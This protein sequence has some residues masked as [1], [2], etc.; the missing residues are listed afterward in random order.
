MSVEMTDGRHPET[1]H[2]LV[3]WV[4][5]TS[6]EAPSRTDGG[7]RLVIV[8]SRSTGHDY[9]PAFVHPS[10]SLHPLYTPS[11]PVPP[12]C[13]LLPFSLPTIAAPTH[14]IDLKSIASLNVA[15]D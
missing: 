9:T 5:I 14:S 15:S 1:A 7:H 6:K 2:S 4:L 12:L 11:P 13:L 3:A 8:A 10:S